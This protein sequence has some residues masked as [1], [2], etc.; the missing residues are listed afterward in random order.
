MKFYIFVGIGAAINMC[1][2]LYMHAKPGYTHS[3]FGWFLAMWLCIG[4]ITRVTEK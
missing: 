4:I 1:C 3:S 2:A